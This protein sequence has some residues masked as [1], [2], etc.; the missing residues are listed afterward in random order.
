M[1]GKI[2]IGKL[3]RGCLMYCLND[4]QKQHQNDEEIFKN[5]TEIIAFNQCRGVAQELIKQFNR[6][7]ALNQKLLKPVLHI[8]LSLAPNEHLSKD[9]LMEIAEQCAKEF[10]FGNNQYIAVQHLD[11]KHQHMHIV[12]NRIGFDKKT[13]SDSNNYQKIANFCRKAELKYGL[14]QVVSPKKFLSKEQRD[15]PR[16]DERKKMLALSIRRAVNNAKGMEHFV[17]IMQSK[18]YT[19]IMSRGVSFIDDKKVKIKGSEV[20]YSLQKIQQNLNFL[21]RLKT[22]REF[23]KQVNEKKLVNVSSNFTNQVINN[24]KNI[25]ATDQF[26]QNLSATVDALLKPELASEQI[27]PKLLVK[28]KERKKKLGFRL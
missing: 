26:E 12:A 4:K 2:I 20:G 19:V 24:D 23:F 9:K 15:L 22:D 18:G 10:G 6:V 1:I 25:S 17:R 3:F 16:N 21:Q 13:V 5:R 7:R 14:Q 11:T 8:T 27:E 28:K